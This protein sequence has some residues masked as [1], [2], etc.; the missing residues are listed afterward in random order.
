VFRERILRKTFILTSRPVC[1]LFASSERQM[2]NLSIIQSLWIGDR[3]SVMEQLSISSFLKNGHS[4]HLYVYNELK[5][6]PDGVVLLDADQIMRLLKIFKYKDYDSYAGFSDLFRYKLLL[7]KGG[8]WVDTDVVCLKPFRL[9]CDYVLASEKFRKYFLARPVLARASCVIKAPVGSRIMEY[10][11]AESAKRDPRELSWGE[12]GP[13]LLTTA[14]KKFNLEGYAAKTEIFCPIDSWQWKRSISGSFITVWKEKKKMATHGSL[15]LHLW[16]EMWR[17]SGVNKDADF[18]K[19]S[20]Y[21]Q[22][23]Q[24]YLNST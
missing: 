4:F 11:Y 17:R 23:K 13:K 16:N 22:L 14:V 19:N 15:A 2:N 6:V 8:Y 20:I 1:N 21:E 24:R 12:L 18:P 10:C 5:G 3:L 7:E 9:E